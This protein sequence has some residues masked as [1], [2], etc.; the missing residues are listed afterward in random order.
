MMRHQFEVEIRE[1]E[2]G[3]PRL[4]GVMLTEGRAASERRELFAPGSVNWPAD[5]VGIQTQHHGEIEVRAQP[6]RHSDGRIEVR[7]EA[8]D[9]IRAAI[10]AGARYMSVEF[11]SLR[12]KVTRGGIREILEAFVPAPR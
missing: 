12:E 6:V 9:G 2:A 1:V 8:T 7:A 10:A 4:F 5:G 11:M 3:R